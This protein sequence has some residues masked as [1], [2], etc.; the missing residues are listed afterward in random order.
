MS[1][2]LKII[3]VLMMIAGGLVLLVAKSAL[4]EMTAATGIGLGA[5]VLALGAVAD[6]LE[7]IRAHLSARF[8]LRAVAAPKRQEPLPPEASK[9]PDL[10]V[11]WRSRG[12]R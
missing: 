1:G 5:V 8:P 2:F 9:K 10:E 4:H 12:S 6:H 11:S 7:A 3:G